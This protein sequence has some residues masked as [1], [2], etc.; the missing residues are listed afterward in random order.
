MGLNQLLDIGE[1]EYCHSSELPFFHKFV[2]FWFFL[3][4]VTT[5]MKYYSGYRDTNVKSYIMRYI[6]LILE[7]F[8]TNKLIFSY[9]INTYSSWINVQNTI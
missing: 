2:A 3:S 9:Y 6:I 8:N 4:K 7:L 1:V 5:C